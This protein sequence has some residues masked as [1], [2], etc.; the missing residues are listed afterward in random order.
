MAV[1]RRKIL[2]AA[3]K[4]VQK[5]NLDRAI[6][7]YSKLLKEDPEDVRILL[8]VGHLYAKKGDIAHALE[9]YWKVADKY[10]KEGFG[11]QAQAVLQQIIKLNPADIR[12]SVALARLLKDRGL[13]ADALAHLEG[14]YRWLVRH[15]KRAEA[16]ELA[17]EMVSLDP[18]NVAF[19]IR[20]A[21][22]YSR[23]GRRQEAVAEFVVAADLLRA[24]ERFDDFIKVAER[25]LWHQPENAAISKELASLYLRRREPRRALQKLQVCFK[26]DPQDT[27][28]LELLAQAFEQLDQAEKA[29]TILKELARVYQAT[30]KIRRAT[31]AYERVLELVPGD[32]EAKA[33]L[34]ELR[35]RPGPGFERATTLPESAAGVPEEEVEELSEDEIEELPDSAIVEVFEDG[36]DVTTI[37]RETEAFVRYRLYDKA[38]ANLES[39]LESHPEHRQARKML[40]EVLEASG[41]YP[42]A[43]QAYRAYAELVASEDREEAAKVLELALKLVPDDEELVR[44][45]E[46]LSGRS[47]SEVLASAEEAEE[48]FAELSGLQILEDIEAEAEVL[49]PKFATQELSIQG[50]RSP[51]AGASSVSDEEVDL[52]GLDALGLLGSDGESAD[53]VDLS[54]LST[55]ALDMGPA[56]DVAPDKTLPET[57]PFPGMEPDATIREGALTA[58]KVQEMLGARNA[59]PAAEEEGAVLD[60]DSDLDGALA[61]LER[62][63]GPLKPGEAG[64]EAGS[65]EATV[66]VREEEVAPRESDEAEEEDELDLA[67]PLG[68]LW[69]E[70]QASGA[71]DANGEPEAPAQALEGA[72]EEPEAP[73]ERE[74]EPR[75]EPEPADEGDELDALEETEDLIRSLERAGRETGEL[76]EVK[77][78][79]ETAAPAPAEGPADSDLDFSDLVTPEPRAAQQPAP[80]EP[81]EAGF[82]E[83]APL[84]TTELRLEDLADAWDQVS[85]V[86][87]ELSGVG[88]ESEVSGEQEA[89]FAAEAVAEAIRLDLQDVDFLVEQGLYGDAL[90]L[91]AEL[92]D[93]YGSHPL[94]TE[95]RQ[96]VETMASQAGTAGKE[97][98]EGMREAESG[99]GIV[100]SSEELGRKDAEALRLL[101]QGMGKLVDEE[102]AETHFELGI[103]YRDMGLFDQAIEEFKK[104]ARS[105]TREAQAHLMVADCYVQ[106]GLLSDAI[107][108]CKAAL[109][110]EQLSEDEELGIYYQLGDLY[111]RLGDHEEAEYFFNKVLK[112]AGAYRDAEERL[113]RVRRARES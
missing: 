97:G 49:Q 67:G 103:A 16:L 93:Q 40:A 46:S 25:L 42:E 45:F 43:A 101:T 94:L 12:A 28:T 32:E 109:N 83:K 55:G 2:N 62:E 21:E 88:A 100:V 72:A 31:A 52:E 106:Q 108:Q 50:A 19:R 73:A 44:A 5:G 110:A 57:G 11:T 56:Q 80:A 113:E 10:L 60:L 9:T 78:E 70:G 76:P 99:G 51:F 8:Q 35:P 63:L 65:R 68:A 87:E 90:D 38:I 58:E 13:L 18:D 3:Q 39:L 85:E 92:E 33:A 34:A 79:P 96:Q 29:A 7:E 26:A 61:D 77:E 4:Y 75:D 1:N 17:K 20:L 36:P 15:N 69:E 22:A 111:E 23:E 6:E 104:A 102:D 53:V 66:S 89:S 86:S 98:Q 95:K 48:E 112:K 30:G 27:E 54:A 81:E 91:I 47:A 105:K 24:A 107:L 64:L 14:V 41:R 82:G 71:A 37:L 84:A 74:S 59:E